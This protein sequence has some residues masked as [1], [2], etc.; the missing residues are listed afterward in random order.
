[1]TDVRLEVW[2][3]LGAA[4]FGRKISTLPTITDSARLQPVN[5]IG[6]G[7]ASL[8]DVFDRVAEILTTDPVTPA[9]NVRSLIRVYL[10]GDDS[11][12]TEPYAEWLPD[13]VIPPSESESGRYEISGLGREAMIRDAVVEPWDWDGNADFLST[14]PDWIYGGRDIVGPVETTFAPA[15][16]SFWID[17]G[18]TGTAD[19]DIDID[20]GGFQSATVA[21]GDSAFD[22]ETAIEA[23]AYGITADVQGNGTIESP[24]Q[25]RFLDPVGTYTVATDSSGLAGGRIYSNQNQFGK[26]TPVGWTQSLIGATT[27]PHGVVTDFRAS[28]GGGG[29][30]TLPVGCDAWV[31]FL[32][33]EW[34]FPGVQ[35]VRRVIPGGVYT[36]PPV[37]LYAQGASA[38]L[39]VVV[40]DLN[41]N[42]L[43]QEEITVPSNTPTQT[44]GVWTGPAVLGGSGSVIQIPEGVYEIVYRVGHIGAGTPPRILVGCPS[45]TEG[46]PASTIGV[47]VG[48]LYTDWTT[49]HAASPFPQS[50]WVH[51]DGGFYLGLD[52]D[53]AL[54]SAGNAWPRD[55]SITIKRGEQFDRVLAKIVGLGY[56]WRVVPG[57]VD[58]YYL[59]QIFTAPT[60]GVDYSALDTPTIR[61]G[62]DVTRRALR[63]WLA[64]TGALVEG[65][66]QFFSHA[67]DAGARAGWGVSSNYQV[68]LDFEPAPTAVAAVERVSDQLRKTRSLVVNIADIGQPTVPIPGRTYVAGDTLRV[69]DPPLI[70]DDPER[71]WSINYARDESGLNWEVQLGNQSFADTGG[72]G[73]GAGA[74]KGG[75]SIP[76][77]EGVRYL[78]EQQEI[79]RA[80]QREPLP[81][82]IVTGGG[83]VPTLV[84]AAADAS[85][86]SKARADFTCTGVNDQDTIQLA[87][88]SIAVQ[89]DSQSG[90]LGG[91]VWL[92]EGNFQ[93]SVPATPA[94]EVKNRITLQGLNPAGTVLWLTADAGGYVV[95]LRAGAQLKDLSIQQES[96]SLSNPPA[97][98]Q[99]VGV[100][101]LV[102]NCLFVQ[103]GGGTG[104]T[105]GTIFGGNGLIN[106]HVIG[107]EFDQTH[108]DAVVFQNVEY[109]LVTRCRFR[110]TGGNGVYVNGGIQVNVTDNQFQAMESGDAI[111]LEDV[112]LFSISGNTYDGGDPT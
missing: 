108:G 28:L 32:G 70:V 35:T 6:E 10:D 71:V 15:I 17:V 30:P 94:I 68:R 52:F 20:G 22:V 107:C 99:M 55:E 27:I 79:V 90:D 36:L 93:I 77:A 23:L 2:D 78:L 48:D 5:G 82:P 41:E 69:L 81:T 67:T 18:A 1:M 45:M 4:G 8:P 47:I 13:Q 101:T 80:P 96:G 83:S 76:V 33:Q 53:G 44:T 26:L 31:V 105:S 106:Q 112:Q 62:R 57:A 95:Q 89:Q 39:R 51:G 40:R 98:V 21:P 103:V 11:G 88:N 38:D 91:R 25:V 7:R 9:N 86:Y 73:G 87:I 92:T 42:L 58:G 111:R 43:A 46:F 34:Y 109:G 84:V 16:N 110:N 37:W 59:L 49:N 3:R 63:R 64:K 97:G 12:V 75:A 24:W 85:T 66:E 14:W 65:A 60:L 100:D 104:G 74:G 29:D 54:D 50:Y 72:A 19:I 61:G 56:E 102:E